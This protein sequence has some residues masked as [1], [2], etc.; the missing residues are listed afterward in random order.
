[1]AIKKL[2][3]L[4][5][6]GLFLFPNLVLGVSTFGYTELGNIV[7]HPGN[8]IRA[9]RAYLPETSE[10]NVMYIYLSATSPVNVRGA[11][12]DENKNLIALTEQKTIEN[13]EGWMSFNISPPITLTPG[14]YYLGFNSDGLIDWSLAFE[15]EGFE[16]Y[17]IENI[18]YGDW[19]FDPF[20]PPS[21]RTAD[22]LYLAYSE[23]PPPP[24]PPIENKW[25]DISGTFMDNLKATIS[26]LSGDLGLYLTI[27]I[28]LPLAFWFIYRVIG[29]IRM[30]EKT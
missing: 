15:I 7:S 12:W 29:L 11:I 28:G 5:L 14:W 30:R 24:P 10:F 21:S 8:Q 20:H 1:M 18:P 16:E 4:G 23:T 17:Y 9:T 19:T 25:F 13:F 22:S 3:F 26:D 2:L 27:I 6:I